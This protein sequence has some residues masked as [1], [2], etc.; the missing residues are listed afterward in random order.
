MNRVIPRENALE[1]PPEGDKGEIRE[2][3]FDVVDEARIQT[4]HKE[5]Q[6]CHDGVDLREPHVQAY[7]WHLNGIGHK[8]HFR[9]VFC[10]RDCWTEWASRGG[11]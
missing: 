3:E 11:E 7:G 8:S 10:D 1:S 6:A 9:P 5:C 2:V 4:T